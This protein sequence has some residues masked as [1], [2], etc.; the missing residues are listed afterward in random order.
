MSA[1]ALSRSLPDSVKITIVETGVNPV[2]D[3]FYGQVLP[4]QAYAFHL[5]IGLSEPELLLN[6][7]TT[8]AL[9]TEF[10]SWAQTNR[11]WVQAFH[12]PLPVWNGVPL[13]KLIHQRPHAS[14][15]S[16]LISAQ[17]GLKGVFAH[18]SEDRTHPLSRHEYG[19]AFD[20]KQL[21]ALY[22]AATRRRPV[23]MISAQIETLQRTGC[24]HHRT[25]PFR[26][27]NPSRRSI[28]RLHRAARAIA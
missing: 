21:S 18:P 15:Q 5:S 12:Q 13:A 14:L 8:F 23:K 11:S 27:P 26:R 17:A 22:K 20:P 3:M 25:D 24:R 2:E 1:A 28:H 4:P 19:Y 7:G 6:T 10:Q 16:T 9:G